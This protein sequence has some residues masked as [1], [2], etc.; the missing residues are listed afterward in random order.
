M[1][2][3]RALVRGTLTGGALDEARR[4]AAKWGFELPETVEDPAEA[5]W[6]EHVPALEAFL[7]VATQWRTAATLAGVIYVGLDYGAARDG[8]HM[9]GIEVTPE[10]W[11]EL[12]L[13]ETGALKA[14]RE[15][16]S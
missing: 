3:G 2:A 7:I 12:Q 6:P 15:A 5:I 10:L 1:A 9:A 11:G 4:D 16:G 8:L 14:M 13:I